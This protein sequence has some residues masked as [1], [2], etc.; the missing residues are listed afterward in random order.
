MCRRMIRSIFRAIVT[1]EGNSLKIFE[2]R[3][4]FI[5]RTAKI[6]ETGTEQKILHRCFGCVTHPS[7]ARKHTLKM[8]A[9]TNDAAQ[10]GSVNAMPRCDSRVYFSVSYMYRQFCLGF[11]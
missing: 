2:N 4:G 5:L 9:N 8:E 3:S 11:F 10:T 7:S 1:A 6:K